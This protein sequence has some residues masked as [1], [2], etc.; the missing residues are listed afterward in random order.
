[1]AGE[2]YEE[3]QL[4]AKTAATGRRPLAC[5]FVDDD[6]AVKMSEEE[7]EVHLAVEMIVEGTSED[8][9]APSSAVVSEGN[10]TACV[11]TECWLEE[12]QQLRYVP[13]LG[14]GAVSLKEVGS[15][16]EPLGPATRV[17]L[18]MILLAGCLALEEVVLIA[19]TEIAA[20]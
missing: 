18:A 2:A 3:F 4:S 20:M 11:G 13:Q 14:F 7:L 15:E 10:V 12:Q 9:D 16:M 5:V 1:M 19:D 6:G 17:D 8:S